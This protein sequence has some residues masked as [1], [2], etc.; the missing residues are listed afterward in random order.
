MYVV[1]C[2]RNHLPNLI[3]EHKTETKA[4]A[5]ITELCSKKKTS[6]IN[7]QWQSQLTIGGKCSKL[8]L[9]KKKQLQSLEPEVMHTCPQFI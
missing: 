5:H 2:D 8:P 9:T 4:A 3:K 7:T 1:G 6:N